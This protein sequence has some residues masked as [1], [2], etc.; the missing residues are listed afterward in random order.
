MINK[1]KKIC[2]IFE[3]IK[4]ILMLNKNEVYFLTTLYKTHLF[5][6][7]FNAYHIDREIIS[8]IHNISQ[9]FMNCL[10]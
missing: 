4:E 1:T 5:D 9:L 10:T 8:G 2:L 6:P 7:D 3:S